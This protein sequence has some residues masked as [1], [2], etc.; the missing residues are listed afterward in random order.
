MADILI[1]GMEMPK[2]WDLWLCIDTGGTVYNV[3]PVITGTAQEVGTAIPLPEGHGRLG[4]LD[5]VAKEAY[6]RLLEC[7]KY[8]TE[9]QKPY[10]IIRAIETAKTIVPAE[11]GTE[12]A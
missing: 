3:K 5:A 6:R 12:D 9:F 7:E 11:G 1:R 10:E 4:D 2:D 8:G